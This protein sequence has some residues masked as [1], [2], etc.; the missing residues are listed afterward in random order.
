VKVVVGSGMEA[1]AGLTT[2]RLVLAKR[3]HRAT[4]K[5]TASEA[6]MIC[7]SSQ[8]FFGL[9]CIVEPVNHPRQVHR[10]H[11]WIAVGDWKDRRNYQEL[12]PE[13]QPPRSAER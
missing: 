1:T 2:G 12:V 5:V 3:F 8:R 13:G 11:H 10:V 7:I 9:F 6:R 4:V